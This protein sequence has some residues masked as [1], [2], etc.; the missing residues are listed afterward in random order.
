MLD[1][2][3]Y[4]RL[5]SW[6]DGGL[7]REAAPRALLERVRILNLATPALMLVALVFAAYALAVRYLDVYPEVTRRRGQRAQT[8]HRLHP[9]AR[10]PDAPRFRPPSAVVPTPGDRI[11]RK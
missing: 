7:D 4:P 2:R 1:P 9:S 8:R 5:A 3:Q 11:A 6:L 10:L